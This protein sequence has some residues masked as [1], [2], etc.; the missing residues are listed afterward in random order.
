MKLCQSFMQFQVKWKF[1]SYHPSNEVNCILLF[2]PIIYT[3]VHSNILSFWQVREKT[4]WNLTIISKKVRLVKFY[5][6]NCLELSKSAIY[7]I[8]QIVRF[9]KVKFYQHFKQFQVKLKVLTIS[10]H[11]SN[12]GSTASI[13]ATSWNR[14]ISIKFF[15]KYFVLIFI[16]L[17]SNRYS[18]ICEP[19][20]I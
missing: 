19:S 14:T 3:E 5:P 9:F 4:K 13:G 7:T 12:G 8:V 18:I 11:A 6:V 1:F 2:K 17:C 16:W 15:D 10:Y 20:I